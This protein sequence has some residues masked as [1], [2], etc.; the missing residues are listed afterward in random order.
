MPNDSNAN[1]ASNVSNPN[2]A[3]VLFSN[4]LKVLVRDVHQIY[5]NAE[6]NKE[7]CSIMVDK[8]VDGES[9]MR[10]ILGKNNS[11]NYFQEYF[12]RFK[13]FENVLI[14]IRDFTN[15]VSTLE[16]FKKFFNTKEVQNNRNELIKDF[17][18]SME[19]LKF[20]MDVV[21]KLQNEKVDESLRDAEESLKALGNKHDLVA[22]SA[23]IAKN[24]YNVLPKIGQN[25]LS[26]PKIQD[27]RGSTH[28]PIFKKIYKYSEVACKPTKKSRYFNEELVILGKLG[29][30]FGKLPN[31]LQFYG[32]SY[33]DNYDVMVFEWAE[34]GTLKELYNKYHI[35]WTRKI[36]IIRGICRGFVYLRTFKIFHHDVRC[37]NIFVSMIYG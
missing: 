9:T 34:Y 1:D 11:E 20:I 33:V 29:Q 14:N 6:C 7:L 24:S 8:I 3:V 25:E 26:E 28:F 22:Q 18:I 2:D 19:H 32:L 12:L 13:R 30:L 5:V 17:E 27:S 10:K 35:T 36:Q 4:V 21:N 23:N 15:K 37:K 31:I 16:G